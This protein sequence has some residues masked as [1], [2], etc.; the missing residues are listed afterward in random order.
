[1][2]PI[3]AS[4]LPVLLVA[5]YILSFVALNALALLIS[6]FYRKKFQ[7]KSPVGTF[8][9]SLIAGLCAII[10]VLVANIGHRFLLN[11]AYIVLAFGGIASIIGAINLFFIMR[12][13]GK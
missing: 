10:M 2:K 7:T 5:G 11:M 1:M 3:L 6:L 8:L 4:Y 12:R 9:A 13:V